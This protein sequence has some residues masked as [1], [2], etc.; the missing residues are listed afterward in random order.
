MSRH[1]GDI[2]EQ[3]EMW[4]KCSH[5]P[6]SL[7]SSYLQ[8]C[9]YYFVLRIQAYH[10]LQDFSL[11]HKFLLR[12][13]FGGEIISYALIIDGRISLVSAKKL[14]KIPVCPY[15]QRQLPQSTQIIWTNT[16]NLDTTADAMWLPLH[17]EG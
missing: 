12:I 13:F 4:T 8:C 7:S 14:L 10:A 15:L 1:G 16:S 11:S 2:R 3:F 17:S 5:Q 9:Y 6:K